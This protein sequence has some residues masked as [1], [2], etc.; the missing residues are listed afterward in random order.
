MKQHKL[1][2]FPNRLGY[3]LDAGPFYCWE[4]FRP[5][6]AFQGCWVASYF[7]RGKDG[8]ATGSVIKV[9]R[10]TS[11]VDAIANATKQYEPFVF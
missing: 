6:W 8:Q 3:T 2:E 5:E 7:A 4:I 1:V 10:G 9:G 11:M